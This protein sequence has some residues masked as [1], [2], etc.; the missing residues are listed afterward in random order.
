[1]TGIYAWAGERYQRGAG[2][3]VADLNARGG[4]LGQTV[5]LIV[6]DDFCDP[7]QAVALARKLASDGVVFVAGHWCSHASIPAAQVYEQAGVL[8]IAPGSASAKLTDEGGPNVF[9]VCGRDDQQGAKVADYVADNW[10]G[11]GIA[12][13]DDGTTWGVGVADGA[14]RR[15]RERGVTV[16]VDETIAPGQDEYYALTSR[17]QA[18]GVEVLFLGGYHREAGLIFRQAR[19]RGYDLQLIANSAMALE[20]FPMIAGPGLEGTLMAAMTYTG[21]RPQAKDVVGQ[22]HAQG[23]E[24][25]GYTLYAYA[26]VQVWAQAVAAASSLELEPVIA[27]MHSRRFETVLGR[28]GFDANGDVTGFE[29]WGWYVWQADGTYV[30]LEQSS[31]KE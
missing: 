25:L 12:I 7:D 5:E 23:Y 2:L 10:A 27:A 24:P 8:Q 3:A 13:L 22:F 17:M 14:R 11:K 1:M 28:I 29:P 6:G 15:L 16:A 30:P 18:A 4:V 20:D 19:D 26:A 21:D 31:A 9:R